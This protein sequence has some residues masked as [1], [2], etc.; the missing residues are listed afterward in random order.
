MGM[1][2]GFNLKCFECLENHYINPIII[3]RLA[4]S[5]SSP[6]VFTHFQVYV[7]IAS[8]IVWAIHC[9]CCLF[10]GFLLFSHFN[11]ASIAFFLF[12][13]LSFF[14]SPLLLPPPPSTL[15]WHTFSCP[16]VSTTTAPPAPLTSTVTGGARAQPPPSPS[17]PPHHHPPPPA[18]PAHGHAPPQLCYQ[19]THLTA[20]WGPWFHHQ[21][22]PAGRFVCSPQLT[23]HPSNAKAFSSYSSNVVQYPLEEFYLEES[24][25]SFGVTK[26]THI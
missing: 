7:V 5:V 18:P 22:C 20:R 14:R 6:P 19:T 21:K 13:C 4:S 15:H 9:C 10:S 26:N 23:S 12:C 1:N 2:N 8:C 24:V 16:T 3:W 11:L 25:N 17:S